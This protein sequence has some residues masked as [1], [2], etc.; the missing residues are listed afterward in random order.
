M[1]AVELD[2]PIVDKTGAGDSFS[3]AFMAAI[4]HKK[5][6]KEALKW[7]VYN[8]AANITEIGSITG[9]LDLKQMQEMIK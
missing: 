9:I 3:S 6:L 5:S 8:S 2:S 1:D 4:L 7:G